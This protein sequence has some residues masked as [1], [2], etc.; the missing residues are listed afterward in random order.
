[1]FTLLPLMYVSR[2]LHRRR[3][4]SRQQPDETIYD[5]LALPRAVDASFAG[6]MRIDE[7]LID[8]GLSLPV[9]GSL[10]AVARKAP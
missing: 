4:K 7:W 3:G 10:L 2:L 5:E 9:G 1:M 6:A 8:A